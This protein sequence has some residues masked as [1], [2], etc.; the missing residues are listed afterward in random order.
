MTFNIQ[1]FHIK[2]Y[3]IATGSKNVLVVADYRAKY[4]CIEEEYASEWVEALLPYFKRDQSIEGLKLCT[5][6]EIY[7][8][9]KNE[10]TDI[11]YLEHSKENWTGEPKVLEAFH[12]CLKKV[13]D[14]GCLQNH[15]NKLFPMICQI[16]DD[17]RA[18]FKVKGVELLQEF[19][20]IVPMEFFVKFNLHRV[21]YESLKVNVTFESDELMEKSIIFWIKLIKKVELFGGKEFL[22]RSDE[23]LLILCRDLGNTSKTDR[24]SILLS[25][26]G[27]IVDDLLEYCAIRYLRKIVVTICEAVKEDFNC[28]EVVQFG[29]EAMQKVIRNCWIRLACPE[30][31]NI[32][33][34]T[35][36]GDETIQN[37]LKIV[38]EQVKQ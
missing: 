2:E 33:L 6:N 21:L 25:S 11:S 7:L 17:Y 32:I 20:R 35:F 10:I 13:E 36:G 4:G 14:F 15:L 9:E 26:I 31:Q 38:K 16:V 19:I 30:M 23:L 18:K 24:K 1:S 5:Q 12:E 27:S 34:D 28:E 37:L 22:K 29:G 3:L 8:E